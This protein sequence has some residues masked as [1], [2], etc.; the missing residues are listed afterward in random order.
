MR[1]RSPFCRKNWKNFWRVRN[2]AARQWWNVGRLSK[3]QLLPL[4]LLPSEWKQIL[5]SCRNR[6]L[7]MIDV[8]SFSPVIITC[9]H[10]YHN[11]SG[12]NSCIIFYENRSNT[13]TQSPASP[14]S[15]TPID[16]HLRS[17]SSILLPTAYRTPSSSSTL[18][19]PHAKPRLP[20]LLSPTPMTPTMYRPSKIAPIIVHIAT[21]CFPYVT[22][23]VKE[24]LS[25]RQSASTTA[26]SKPKEL[27]R[28]L[29]KWLIIWGYF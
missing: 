18:P 16:S 8:T 2:D 9:P 13:I 21:W 10:I 25:L 11:I 1:T 23:L 5:P 4:C 17:D 27:G 12:I 29:R 26:I 22:Q 24:R 15:H 6:R 20:S 19:N 3:K 28:A 14:W 7:N